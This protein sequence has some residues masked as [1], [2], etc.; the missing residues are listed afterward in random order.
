LNSLKQAL[1]FCGQF[2]L[3]DIAVLLYGPLTSL[4]GFEFLGINCVTHGWHEVLKNFKF[5]M[6]DIRCGQE[7]Q[8]W[9]RPVFVIADYSE[10]VWRRR[11]IQ[12]V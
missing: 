7:I 5:D 9:H 1:L 6:T 11:K 12:C 8:I 2:A 3:N 10:K 4:L